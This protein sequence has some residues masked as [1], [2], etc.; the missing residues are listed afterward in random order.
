MRE[1]LGGEGHTG[2]CGDSVE[3]IAGLISGVHCEGVS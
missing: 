2:V 1:L 3:H